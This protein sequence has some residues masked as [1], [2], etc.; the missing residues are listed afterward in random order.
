MLVLTRKLNESIKIG[1]NI[2]ITIVDVSGGKVRIGVDAPKE[3]RVIRSEVYETEKQNCAA[4][5]SL[6]SVTDLVPKGKPVSVKLPN[7]SSYK[8]KRS[9]QNDKQE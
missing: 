8:A 7:G 2:T 4:A 6:P 3:I 9:K 5:V 1:E